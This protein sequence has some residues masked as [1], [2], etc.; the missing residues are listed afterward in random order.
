MTVSRVLK[1]LDQYKIR[2]GFLFPNKYKANKK[3]GKRNYTMFFGSIP[4]F[5]L[6]VVVVS[7][8]LAYLCTMVDNM[9]NGTLDK[10]K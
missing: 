6:T 4:G 7:I 5:L 1:N 3:L 2:G 8:A 10:W 9:I